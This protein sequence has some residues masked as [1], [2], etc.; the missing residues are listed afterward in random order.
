MLDSINEKAPA[1]HGLFQ[2]HDDDVIEGEDIHGR[3]HPDWCRS[4]LHMVR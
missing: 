4:G 1:S 2:V 3:R